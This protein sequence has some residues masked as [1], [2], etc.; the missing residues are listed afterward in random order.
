MTTP[1]DA[2]TV[3][4]MLALLTFPHPPGLSTAEWLDQFPRREG[5]FARWAREA[6]PALATRVAELEAD[7]MLDGKAMT[8]TAMERDSARASLRYCREEV[9]RLNN[10]LDRLKETSDAEAA[11]LR[12]EV[13]RLTDLFVEI[14]QWA[15]A[16]PVAVFPEPDFNRANELLQAG[17]MSIDAVSASNM[18]HVLSGLNRIVTAA[19]TTGEAE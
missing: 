12:G 3:E 4:R 17:G 5:E 8:E 15:A 16:Y 13:A 14:Q 18:R 11:A 6:V 19:L 7:R 9:G 1:T 10:Q 2:E